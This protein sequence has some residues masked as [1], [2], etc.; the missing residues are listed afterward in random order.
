MPRRRGDGLLQVAQ[1]LAKWLGDSPL[2]AWTADIEI[3]FMIELLGSQPSQPVAREWLLKR[4]RE[5]L[6]AEL[7]RLGASAVEASAAATALVE[8]TAEGLTEESLPLNPTMFYR[9][10]G[11]GRPVLADYQWVGYLKDRISGY[12]MRRPARRGTGTALIQPEEVAAHCWVE[13]RWITL[14]RPDGTPVEA[15]EEELCQRP[16]RRSGMGKDITAIAASEQILPPFRCQFR[17]VVT[18][19]LDGH[20]ITP[21]HVALAL[22]IGR[23]HGFGQWRGGGKGRFTVLR[24]DV[25]GWEE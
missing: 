15:P 7:H 16:L 22:A 17:L 20:L 11:T 23:Y 9:E 6:E 25:E 4:Q 14:Y 10:P 8:E 3:E 2:P 5:Q 24:Y 12:R 13:P 21:T 18:S 19:P 1:P